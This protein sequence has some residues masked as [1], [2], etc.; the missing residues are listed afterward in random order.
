MILWSFE[1]FEGSERSRSL[2][3]IGR[4]GLQLIVEYKSRDFPLIDQ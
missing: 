3:M 2:K 1:G 4:L